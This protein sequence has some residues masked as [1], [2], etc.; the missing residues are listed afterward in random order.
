MD[1]T[2]EDVRDCIDPREAGTVRDTLRRIWVYGLGVAIVAALWLNAADRPASDGPAA[3]DHVN[4]LDL[5]T[6]AAVANSVKSILGFE[7]AVG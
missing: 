6:R 7:E 5:S 3:A 2:I 4:A 1:R